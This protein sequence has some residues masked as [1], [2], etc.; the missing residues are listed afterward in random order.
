MARNHSIYLPQPGIIRAESRLRGN[1]NHRSRQKQECKDKSRLCLF[2][3]MV[4]GSNF[5]IPFIPSLEQWRG[6]VPGERNSCRTCLQT[7]GQGMLEGRIFILWHILRLQNRNRHEIQFRV[8]SPHIGEHRGR[9]RIR[10]QVH[11]HHKTKDP[12]IRRADIRNPL[13]ILT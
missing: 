7:L 8:F 6:W 9:C 3:A 12:D 5:F 1:R 11:Q 2:G 10:F 13:H 4:G